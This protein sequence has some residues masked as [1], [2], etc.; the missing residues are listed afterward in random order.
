M[1][2][3]DETMFM[4]PEP[5][6][7]PVYSPHDSIYAWLCL[8]FAFLFCQAVP[9]TDHPTGGFLLILGLFLTA[10]LVFRFKK[11]KPV[12]PFA[13]ISALVIS[14]A[15]IL[16][17]SPFLV[18]LAYTYALAC[19]CYFVYAAFGNRIESG[20]S[21]YIYIDFIRILFVL[22]FRSMTALFPAAFTKSKGSRLALKLLIGIGIA[23]IPTV[24]ILSLLSYDE[25]FMKILDDIF[26][27][28][29]Q[30]VVHTVFSLI[31]TL[32]LAMYGFGLYASASKG[33]NNITASDCQ[34]NLKRAQILP[35]ITAIAAVTPIL[36]L[37][38]IFFI[39][40][41]QYYIS[42]FTGVLPQNFSYAEYARQ[43]FFELCVVSVINLL[44][45]TAIAFFIKRNEQNKSIILKIVTP[46]F[47]I[48]TLILISTAIAKLIMYIDYY[49]L[50]QKRIYA[51]WLMVVIGI[52]FLVITLGQFIRKIKV[53]ALSL[54]VSI[55]MFA[56]LCLC[57]VNALTAQYNTERYLNG[58]LETVDLVLMEELG[59]SAVPSL[60]QLAKTI[61][62]KKQ[63][64]LKEQIDTILYYN[65]VNLEA[66]QNSIFNFSVPSALAKLALKEY[67]P[68][69]PPI[70]TYGVSTVY[71]NGDLKE[72]DDNS[73]YLLVQSSGSTL[74]YCDQDYPV[75]FTIDK[76]TFN[77]KTFDMVYHPADEFSAAWINLTAPDESFTMVLN[78]VEPDILTS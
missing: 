36:F 43:G 64:E 39:S 68:Q 47:C 7:K 72:F 49:G 71:S 12:C 20:F 13:P 46:L 35:Q 53:V 16:T 33:Q 30:Q 73:N 19:Y 41:W 76:I 31:F 26:S 67:T 44:M 57:N 25:G 27:L 75:T 17:E 50:T 8:V 40:Q 3:Q 15:L 5:P 63:S 48:S 21:D 66:E 38:V 10:I 58:T 37:Y 24:I 78:A 45:I 4:P 14:A 11:L 9:V 23:I 60:V 65:A 77:G 32:P 70:G 56:G 51:M 42:G 62:S 6:E 74:H 2:W 69:I 1:N 52:V 34:T 59:D 54:T 55:V 61:D 29:S 28:D 22:P 18:K